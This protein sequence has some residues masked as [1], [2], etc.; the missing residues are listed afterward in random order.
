MNFKIVKITDED[1]QKLYTFYLDEIVQLDYYN[2]SKSFYKCSDKYAILLYN[3]GNAIG[4]MSYRYDIFNLFV[5]HSYIIPI[6]REIGFE[7]ALLKALENKYNKTISII[8]KI[9]DSYLM[10]ILNDFNYYRVSS[11][12]NKKFFDVFKKDESY[13][14]TKLIINIEALYD[15]DKKLMQALKKILKLY[16]IKPSKENLNSFRRSI[17][18]IDKMYFSNEITLEEYDSKRFQ[19]FLNN[20]GIKCDNLLCKRIYE[21][22]KM[23]P[24]DGAVQFF[25]SLGRHKRI[26]II[27]ALDPKYTNDVLSQLKLKH[28]TEVY[29]QKLNKDGIYK[30][31]KSNKHRTKM[32]FCYIDN[33]NISDDILGLGIDT[34]KIS[35]DISDDTSYLFKKEVN[36]FKELQKI[37]AKK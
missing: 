3:D 20:Y 33:K 22:S 8:V 11:N 32:E 4:F 31:I 23:K 7:E 2:Y 30:I 25:K 26:F 5:S 13:H 6:Y 28:I 12:V 34:F 24:K 16:N 27:S 29:M 35:V 17:A 9:C 37:I 36:T 18:S 14:Y 21:N 19:T 10:K 1:F 15:T